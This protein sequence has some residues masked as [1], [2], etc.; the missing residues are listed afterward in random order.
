M[1]RLAKKV[2]T[3]ILI[4]LFFRERSILAL[5]AI[6]KGCYQYLKPYL[7]VLLNLILEESELNNKLIWAISCWTSSR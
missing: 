4:Y 5:G 6:S 1:S 3:Y 2:K 7:N